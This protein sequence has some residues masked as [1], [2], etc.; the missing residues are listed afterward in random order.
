MDFAFPRQQFKFKSLSSGKHVT[1]LESDDFKKW[2]T[3]EIRGY[4]IQLVEEERKRLTNRREF[5]HKK[6]DYRTVV[7][8]KFDVSVRSV[9]DYGVVS[10]VR[11]ATMPEILETAVRLIRKVSPVKS[12]TYLSSHIIMVNGKEVPLHSVDSIVLS[13]DDTVQLMNV[14][15]YARKMEGYDIGGGGT[16]KA[17]KPRKR[18]PQS[19][20]APQGVYRLVA[21]LLKL[22]YGNSAYIKYAFKSLDS[23]RTVKVTRGKGKGS[24][25]SNRYPMIQIGFSTGTKI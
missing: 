11:K 19:N 17:G 6:S 21:R 23:A 13:P 25:A 12:G 16:T 5:P 18:R 15:E 3:E 24:R 10:Y 14:A 22:Q 20:Y 1:I 2:S 9:K 4:Q 7:D 8:R